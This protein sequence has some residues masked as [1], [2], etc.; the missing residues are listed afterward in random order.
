MK[1]QRHLCV[2]SSISLQLIRIRYPAGPLRTSTYIRFEFS[3]TIWQTRC[4][5]LHLDCKPKKSTD[6]SPISFSNRRPSAGGAPNY[7]RRLLLRHLAEGEALQVADD[8]PL[9]LSHVLRIRRRGAHAQA[10]RFGNRVA[11][12]EGEGD[13][14]VS[15]IQHYRRAM[16]EM[17]A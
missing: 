1:R 17:L 12:A 4:S 9:Q 14:A 11:G 2:I 8:D 10:G 5:D 13:L 15:L 3:T 6:P 7:R 16:R